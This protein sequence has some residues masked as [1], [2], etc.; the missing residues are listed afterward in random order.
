MSLVFVWEQ[1]PN[2][3]PNQKR[4]LLLM[5]VLLLLAFFESTMYEQVGSNQKNQEEQRRQK[6]GEVRPNLRK[7]QLRVCFGNSEGERDSKDSIDEKNQELCR[8]WKED[9]SL[10]DLDQYSKRCLYLTVIWKIENRKLM[11][12]I[13]LAENSMEKVAMFEE[14]E[15]VENWMEKVV[16]FEEEEK[17]ENWMEKV[18]MKEM[19]WG[20]QKLVFARV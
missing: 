19:H 12:L 1:N 16:M 15:K 7:D 10:M 3:S 13:L 17:I 2:P 8:R 6:N 18:A 11:V 5:M 4:Q 20:E 9:A 14:E